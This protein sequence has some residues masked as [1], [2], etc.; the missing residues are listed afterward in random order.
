M[1]YKGIQNITNS[2]KFPDILQKWTYNTLIN[3]FTTSTQLKANIDAH[4]KVYQWN[5]LKMIRNAA[6]IKFNLSLYFTII[7]QLINTSENFCFSIFYSMRTC[8]FFNFQM[9]IRRII[10]NVLQATFV[11]P[12]TTGIIKERRNGDFSVHDGSIAGVVLLGTSVL[13]IFEVICSISITSST[14]LMDG[15]LC[16]AIASLI[17]CSLLAGCRSCWRIPREPH[18]CDKLKLKFLWIF[19][20]GN[21][22]F[23]AL[24]LAM[25]AKCEIY[26]NIKKAAIFNG[27]T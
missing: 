10:Y 12:F 27:I 20:F 26:V 14:L 25:H 13:I 8:F 24:T 3:I 21:I 7:G 19:C 18:P 23:Q 4:L 1:K 11:L 17:L 16:L 6:S 22:T 9:S 15:L 5:D 2:K